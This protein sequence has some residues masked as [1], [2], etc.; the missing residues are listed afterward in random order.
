M[1]FDVPSQGHLPFE[2]R[3]SHLQRL[4]PQAPKFEIGGQLSAKGKDNV[5]LLDRS[6]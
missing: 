1:I 5:T 6:L 3:V 2:Q 4:F